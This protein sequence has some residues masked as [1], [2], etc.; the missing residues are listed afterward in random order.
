M[1]S[2]QKTIFIPIARGFIVRNI[3]RSGVL[4][5]LKDAG[6]RIVIFFIHK[7][8]KVP[9]YLRDE[10][11]DDSVIIECVPPID[12]RGYSRFSRATKM[13][14][15]SDSSWEH[16]QMG[17]QRNL[18]RSFYWKYIERGASWVLS[19]FSVLKRIARY[20]EKKVFYRKTYAPYF[21][22]YKP[23][24]V[25]STSVI[26]TLDIDMMKEA[27]KRGIKTIAMPKGWDNITKNFYRFLPD[28][29]IV[30]NEPMKEGAV[31]VQ[32]VPREMITVRGF[33]QFDWYAK[34]DIILPRERFFQSLGLSPERKLIFFGSEGRWAPGEEHIVSC[35]AG[36]VENNA[37]SR[38]AS[39]LVRPHF[40]DVKKNRFAH[41]E[42]KH[43]TSK[44]NFRLSDFFDDNWDPGTEE[45]IHLANLLYHCDVLVTVAS[46]LTLDA[47]C[48]NKP[49]INVAFKI[50]HHPKTGRDLS[51]LYYTQDHYRWVLGVGGVDLVQSENE[52]LRSIVAYL[53]DPR[54]NEEERS[55][56]V[57]RLCF[58]V[59]GR[60]SRRI[61]EAIINYVEE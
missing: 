51:E 33:P 2:R 59:D 43:I 36:W 9:Q 57:S 46:T 60:S 8:M 47:A 56:L 1:N 20:I 52:L 30:Q 29:L 37:F 42:G 31:R 22:A 44:I 55:R 32:G 49:L 23:D 18:N 11:E 13:L 15:Y 35:L 6:Y 58:K 48:F 34:T 41:F 39:L 53:K 50:L 45:T 27:R 25:F 61:A 21:D 17:N 16:S 7:G 38:P 54:R 12:M 4:A 10:F 14:V 19:R 40:S 5:H 3:L 26:S 24:V 28:R